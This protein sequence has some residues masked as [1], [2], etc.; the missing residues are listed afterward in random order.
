MTLRRDTARSRKAGLTANSKAS[1]EKEDTGPSERGAEKLRCKSSELVYFTRHLATML[2]S[3]V[4]LVQGLQVLCEQCKDRGLSR[5]L[6]GTL[7]RLESG[8]YLSKAMSPYPGIFDSGYLAMIRMGEKSGR[9]H[10]TL[11]SLA[12]WKE[13][14]HQMR[15]K[16][17]AALIY[18]AFV[19]TLGCALTFVFFYGVM[20]SMMSIFEGFQME[21]PMLTRGMMTLTRQARNYWAWLLFFGCAYEIYLLIKKAQTTPK[22][23]LFVYRLFLRVPILGLA[24]QGSGLFRLCGAL[25]N[26]IE[27]GVPLVSAWS[28]AAE[29]SGSPELMEDTVRVKE[30]IKDGD[31]LA[32][33][34]D[35]RLYPTQFRQMLSVGAESSRLVEMLRFCAELYASDVE[36]QLELFSAMLEPVFLSV[37]ATGVLIIILSILLPL[38]GLLAHLG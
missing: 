1:T 2:N 37:M 19:V 26:L 10:E 34:L 11:N 4:N 17:K 29:V 30:R 9:L 35:C 20:P 16:L 12:G 22:G 25:A 18:P 7:K 14:D 27:V 36:R 32:E 38:Y 21:L 6:E 23:R 8:H 28:F 24:L 5:A 15:E 13:N 3:G 33:A 31:E